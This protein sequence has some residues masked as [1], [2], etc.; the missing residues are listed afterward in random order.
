MAEE[1]STNNSLQQGNSAPARIA[2][3]L[4]SRRKE[5]LRLA[6]SHG[7]HDVRFFGSVV[8][9]QATDRSDLDVL[10]EFETGRSLLDRIAL[11]QDLEDLLGIEVDVVTERSVHRD[12]R[13]EIVGSAQPL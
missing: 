1:H 7:A 5:I 4:K 11:M 3:L 8:R 10:V 13:T 2:H 9:N 6:A 12:L